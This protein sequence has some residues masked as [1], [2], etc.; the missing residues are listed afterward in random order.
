MLN[1]KI[2]WDENSSWQVGW[3]VTSKGASGALHTGLRPHCDHFI[4]RG[5]GGVE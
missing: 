1:Q 5:G 3:A 2:R 4:A